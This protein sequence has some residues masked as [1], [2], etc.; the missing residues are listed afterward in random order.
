M[1]WLHETLLSGRFNKNHIN[2]FSSN[3][4]RDFYLHLRH[5]RS[6]IIHR[7]KEENL[8]YADFLF[9][10]IDLN[11]HLLGMNKQRSSLQRSQTEFEQ[12]EQSP[13][14]TFSPNQDCDLRGIFIGPLAAL[15]YLHYEK[16]QRPIP[17]L[18]AEFIAEFIRNRREV[19]MPSD[20]RNICSTKWN[21]IT[22]FKRRNQCQHYHQ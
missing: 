1:N 18:E 10:N 14:A 9:S 2:F 11:R 5:L 8:A 22:T 3:T 16:R 21:C 17:V 15:H 19:V 7:C 4:K 12:K 20:H 6:P 13:S